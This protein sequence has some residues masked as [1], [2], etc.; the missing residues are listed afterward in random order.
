M[1]STLTRRDLF[2][3][4]GA[5]VAGASLAALGMEAASGRA[6]QAAPAVMGD[7]QASLPKA[8][9]PRAVVVGGGWSG[10]TVAKYLKKENPKF[11][12]VLI[13]SRPNFMSCPLSNI[14]MVDLVTLEFLSHSY[15]DAAKDNNYLFLNATVLDVD[16]TARKVA[17]EQGYVSYD[18]LVLAPGIDYN[19][20]A[21]GVTDPE[22]RLALQT[23]YPAGFKPGSEHLSIKRKIAEFEGGVFV[24]TVPEGNYRCLP[25]PYERACMIASAFKKNKIKGKVLILDAH[26]DITIKAN[27]FH[28]AFNELYKDYIEYRPSV[29]IVGVDPWKR[30]IKGE[31]DEFKFDDAAIYPRIRAAALLENA[32]VAD[33]KGPQMEANIDV[34]KYNVVGDERVYVSGDARPMGFSKSGNTARSEAQYVAKIV[35]AHSE[36]KTLPPWT[37]PHTLCYSVVQAEPM[38]AISVDA[39]YSYDGKGGFAF[40]NVKMNE[41]RSE[42]Q[43]KLNLEWARGHYRDMF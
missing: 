33:L 20:A 18:Y 12:V 30:V 9:G 15:L 39:G 27:G 1:S 23:D 42:A 6:V 25:A 3:A 2:K 13:D 41:E 35:A 36:G 8:K 21:I 29:K 24:Q 11:D 17:T 7:A 43:G 22:A 4:S 40:A 19:Y 10:L 34:L 37:S 26:P 32:G 31:F 5:T 38:E 28:A 14:W 16:R